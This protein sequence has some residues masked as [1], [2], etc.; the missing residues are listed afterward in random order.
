MYCIVNKFDCQLS[1]RI[2]FIFPLMFENPKQMSLDKGLLFLM[3]YIALGM[4]FDFDCCHIT[5]HSAYV[6]TETELYGAKIDGLLAPL[7]N[8]T[9]ITFSVV[10]RI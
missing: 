10:L 5:S 1:S 7:T 3:P 2:F 8:K 6:A 4:T 9:S